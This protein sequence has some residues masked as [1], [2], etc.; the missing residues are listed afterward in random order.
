[1]AIL[2]LDV[3]TTCIKAQ[4][5]DLKGKILSENSLEYDVKRNNGIHEIDI[6]A[7][8]NSLFEVIANVT[9]N[10]TLKVESICVSSLGESFVPVGEN[11]EIL[12]NS[13]LYSDR[14]GEEQVDKLKNLIC[15]EEIASICGVMPHAMYSLPKIMWIKENRPEI[16]QKTSKFLLIGSYISYL[17]TGL[18]YTDY[19]LAARTLAFDVKNLCWSDRM[20]EAGGIDKDKL[21]NLIASAKIIGQVTKENIEK[22]NLM[23]NCVVISGG[24]DQVCAAVGAG[25]KAVGHCNDGTGTVEC[26]TIMFDEV[27]RNMKYYESGY[28]VVPYAIEN[29]YVTYAF[30]FTGGALLKWFR[31]KLAKE[32][33]VSLKNSGVD[34]YDVYCKKD[35]EIPTKLLTLPHFT[36]GATPYMDNDSV[37]AIVGL[38]LETSK[39]EIF[40]S[41][42][43]GATY[44]MKVNLEILKE[45]GVSIK[46]CTATGGGAKSKKW[47]QIKADILDKPIYPLL[48]NEGGIFG[49]FIMSLYGLGYE[50]SIEEAIDKFVV[51][52]EP[53][54]A[55]M[56]LS[57]QYEEKFNSYKKLYTNI[58]EI[59]NI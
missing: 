8:T 31:D 25:V 1:M 5:F 19:S 21:P 6:V 3:G 47:L 23:E 14:R 52:G 39:D 7:M 53:S 16:Y 35:V 34:I 11:G 59:Y 27:P 48:S 36:G 28:A 50:K 49:C 22:L 43:E 44:E 42:M 10:S 38:T 51:R 24:H 46:E 32:E 37:G 55:N 9:R 26:M 41:L 56:N 15:Q 2:G 33:A 4:V 29:S 13:M 18:Y 17:L 40:Y 45:N 54:K 30:N 58:K 12:A 57:K 20:L